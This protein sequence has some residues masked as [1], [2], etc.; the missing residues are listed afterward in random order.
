MAAAEHVTSIRCGVA[1]VEGECGRGGRGG[2]W[3]F[4]WAIARDHSRRNRVAASPYL[5]LSRA[6]RRRVARLAV[7]D[8]SRRRRPS[9]RSEGGA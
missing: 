1:L 2:A 6:A 4:R 8:S 5:A 7:R 3:Q 9:L